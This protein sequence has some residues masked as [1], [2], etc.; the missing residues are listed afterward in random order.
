MA[1]G[2]TLVPS[3]AIALAVVASASSVAGAAD[4]SASDPWQTLN[5]ATFS[6]NAA[7]ASEI[8]EPVT[9]AY[10]KAVPEPVQAGIDNVFTNLREPL[11]AVSSGLQGDFNNAGV[12]I[13][14]FAIN[15]TAGIVGIFDVAT[16][17]GWVSRPEDIGATLCAYGIQTGPYLVLPVLGPSTVRETVGLVTTYAV[18]GY[19][20]AGD[21]TF[22]YIVTDR[23]VAGLSN[24]Q[25]TPA[26]APTPASGQQAAVTDQPA[27]PAAPTA[28]PY[29][30]QR[31]A[32]LE[33]RQE[34][35]NDAIPA[36]QLK[37]SPLGNITRVP[38]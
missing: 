32:Y 25:G 8:G 21:S 15:T 27:A 12:S 33:L 11:T 5:R 37:A 9:E 7:I 17:M 29:L 18:V 31:D 24:R 4:G 36:T 1:A 10:R 35:C 22:G 34:I 38:G 3:L 20:V 14:R 16:A 26:A 19:G 6:L 28:D 2:S 13:G 30:A 23:V